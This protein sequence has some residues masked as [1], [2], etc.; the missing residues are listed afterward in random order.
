M[1]IEVGQVVGGFTVEREEEVAELGG[2]AYVMEH[3]A[4]GTR[5]VALLNDDVEMSFS[6]SFAT[7]AADDTGVFHILEHSMLCGSERYPVKKPFTTMLK[8]SMQTYLNAFT[9]PD[10][11]MYPVA[12]TNEQDLL[13]LMDVYMDAVLQP[14]FLKDSN[15]FKQEGWHVECTDGDADTLGFSGVVYNEMKGALSS[16]V[17]YALR[18]VQQA[19]FPRG[20]Y[21]F[22]SGGDP[23]CITNLR[24]ED[25]V[26]TYK[27]HYRLDNCTM[28]LYGAVDLERVL[29]HLDGTHLQPCLARNAACAAPADPNP[30]VFQEPVLALEGSCV[31]RGGDEGAMIA[32]GS[33]L[34][35][36]YDIM[37]TTASGVLCDALFGN[38]EA[39]LRKMLLES[40][41]CGDVAACNLN[42]GCQGHVLVIALA[43]DT[44]KRA[45]FLQLI[46][47]GCEQVL[48]SGQLE[49]LV[50][51]T[52]ATL[53]F[54]WR[55]GPEGAAGIAFAQDVNACWPY[56][57]DPLAAVHY[58][59]YL[60]WHKTA[61]ADGTY[62]R[63]LEELFVSYSHAACVCF[64]PQED[65]DVF[66]EQQRIAALTAGM[67]KDDLVQASEKA[68]E[69][70]RLRLE[71]ER[72]AALA[73][74]PRLSRED[75]PAKPKRTHCDDE[76]VLGTTISRMNAPT[77]GIDYV[78]YYFDLSG[79]SLEDLQLLSLMCALVGELQ[80]GDLCAQEAQVQIKKCLGAV[81]CDVIQSQRWEKD[82]AYALLQ[83]GF[84]TLGGKREQSHELFW[85]LFSQTDF[86]DEAK[87]RQIIDLL[88][89]GIEQTVSSK[90]PTYAVTR[91]RR[92]YSASQM[93]NDAIE[94][95]ESY[96][97]LKELQRM[98]DIAPVCA[99]LGELRDWLIGRRPN[100]V[101]FAG[102]DEGLELVKKSSPCM[103]C[104]NEVV[105]AR[106]LEIELPCATGEG[107]AF[108]TSVAANAAV[109]LPPA[110]RHL[111]GRDFLAQTILNWDYLW[112]A[113]RVKG[114]AYGCNCSF[115]KFGRLILVSARDPRIDGTFEDFEAACLWLAG[116]EFSEE[117]VDGLV[118]SAIAKADKPKK[119]HEKLARHAALF[120]NGRPCEDRDRVR[121]EILAATPADLRAL[122]EQLRAYKLAP[123]VCS[124]ANRDMLEDSERIG[125]WS[126]LLE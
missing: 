84:A 61:L 119:P 118:I 48:A 87:V 38:V 96:R 82:E 32:F 31:V 95:V 92:A 68:A 3:K 122:G 49:E 109:M 85:K 10:Y 14:L 47:D 106:S 90:A 73:T 55:E 103:R 104:K 67:S 17:R 65:A 101:C 110:L 29:K 56:G 40:G 6:V 43:A 120:F 107:F 77:H 94:G 126:D 62:A 112:D 93:L 11:T 125:T 2:T 50:D 81:E 26:D 100:F 64:E 99:R 13:N 111:D 108:Q 8:T 60:A 37:R 52:V 39:P 41:I 89:L 80:A 24:Y 63:M 59:N 27:R 58:E 74:L 97:F 30:L 12:S 20:T 123:S 45:E 78:D 124:L 21:G 25:F 54:A 23:A 98:D 46:K 83:L 1:G 115:D 88:V 71:P 113:V 114:G 51:A 57:A 105:P 117:E 16:P 69:L 79:L 76:L 53:E 66:C 28:T 70:A 18:K 116:H 22:E 19:L 42:S 91:A 86:S 75:L 5:L 9:G 4:S 121:A 33:V 34:P 7:P 72:P 36:S 44:S 102:D 35:G 15:V